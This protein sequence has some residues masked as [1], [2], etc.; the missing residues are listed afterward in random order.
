MLLSLLSWL[1]RWLAET[2]R[3]LTERELRKINN[4]VYRLNE[5]KPLAVIRG[6]APDGVK[7]DE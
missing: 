1:I 2:R 3:P 4:V 5:L 6:A 7:P